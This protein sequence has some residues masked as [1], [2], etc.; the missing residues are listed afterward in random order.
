MVGARRRVVAAGA[1]SNKR[2][3]TLERL[4]ARDLCE[5]LEPATSKFSSNESAHPWVAAAAHALSRRDS[6]AGSPIVW[7]HSK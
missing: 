2:P 6:R 3:R 4:D 7:P 1:L 5:R